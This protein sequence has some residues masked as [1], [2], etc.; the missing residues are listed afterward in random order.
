MDTA[1]LEESVRTLRQRKNV[2]ARLP[3]GRKID[4]L[5]R[6]ARPVPEYSSPGGTDDIYL[7]LAEDTHAPEVRL[8]RH[9]LRRA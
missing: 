4:Y 8:T 3:L 5:N 7:R 1:P 9:Y 6:S 2:W